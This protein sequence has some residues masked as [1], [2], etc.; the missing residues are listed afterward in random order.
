[1]VHGVGDVLAIGNS[2]SGGDDGDDTGNGSGGG[3]C[4]GALGGTG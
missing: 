2:Y 1:M 4:G 3:G